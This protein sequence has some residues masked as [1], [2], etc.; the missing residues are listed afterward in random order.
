MDCKPLKATMS[1]LLKYNITIE[2]LMEIMAISEDLQKLQKSDSNTY[3]ELT[4]LYK[5]YKKDMGE[6]DK[7]K[8]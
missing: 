3:K 7:K 4:K 2:E 8:K 1:I 5:L 6:S